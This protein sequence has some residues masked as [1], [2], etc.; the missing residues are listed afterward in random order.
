[1]PSMNYRDIRLK[2]TMKVSIPFSERHPEQKTQESPSSSSMGHQNPIKKPDL[3]KPD[4]STSIPLKMNNK[5]DTFYAKGGTYK[6]KFTTESSN[7]DV[8]QKSID[9]GI[10]MNLQKSQKEHH[11]F[12]LLDSDYKEIYKRIDDP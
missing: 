9:R 6:S 10:Y 7:V 2:N 4:Y 11:N 8:N 5:R 3:I 12:A 1:M